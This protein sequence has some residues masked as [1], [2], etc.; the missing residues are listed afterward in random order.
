MGRLSAYDS[1]TSMSYNKQVGYERKNKSKYNIHTAR[2]GKAAQT[3]TWT[4]KSTNSTIQHTNK[5][6]PSNTESRTPNSR[7]KYKIK[8]TAQYSHAPAAYDHKSPPPSG[9]CPNT[10]NTYAYGTSCTSNDFSPPNVQST[11][12]T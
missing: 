1:G 8:I 10:Q 7:K 9:T 12:C 5:H 3:S 11:S 6:Q 4:R 2:K